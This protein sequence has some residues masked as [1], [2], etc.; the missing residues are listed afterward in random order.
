MTF[1]TQAIFRKTSFSKDIIFKD[2]HKRAE[3]LS[4]SPPARNEAKREPLLGFL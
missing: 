2:D 1:K 4:V 3:R